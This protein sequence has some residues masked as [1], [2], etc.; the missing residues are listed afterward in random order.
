MERLVKSN[1]AILGVNAS[2]FVDPNGMGN[3]GKAY[4][5]VISDGEMHQKMI[6]WMIDSMK[7][8]IFWSYTIWKI[9]P[10]ILLRS[11]CICANGS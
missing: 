10:S 6:M 5:L 8:R 9:F 1:G 4:G 3:G 2:G 7:L 11:I